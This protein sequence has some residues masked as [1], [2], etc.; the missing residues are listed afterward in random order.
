MVKV[1]DLDG[2]LLD[3][4]GVWRWVDETF[5]GRHGLALTEEYNEYVAHSIFPDAARFTKAYYQLDESETEIMSA[6]HSL[7]Y[8]AYAS[9]L[10]LKPGAYAYLERC[11]A[12]G[13]RTALYTS[14]E[15]SLCRAALEHHHITGFFDQLY[16]AQELGLEKKY[17]ASFRSLSLLLGEGPENC[18]LFDDSP[19]ACTAAK[20]AG[21]R[22]IGV[23][24]SFFAN[25]RGEMYQICDR[26]IDGFTDLL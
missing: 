10:P 19:V 25:R 22:V 15:P 26:M 7:A 20:A 12:Q 14:S 17:Q 4:N 21:W 9:E 24:D 13:E 23:R 5:V 18:L 11:R 2:T 8:R 6:W 1:F 16:F 3:S